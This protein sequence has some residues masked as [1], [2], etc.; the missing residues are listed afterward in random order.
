MLTNYLKIA[1]RNLVRNKVYSFI[2][3]GGLAVGMAVAMLIGLWMLDELSFNKCHDNYLK[4]GRVMTTFYNGKEPGDTGNAIAIPVADEL[5]TKYPN[6]F[7]KVALSSWN[8]GHIVAVGDKKL[9][10]EGMWVESVFPEMLSLKMVKGNQKGL[11]DPSAILLTESLAKAI[12]G[13]KDPLNKIVKLDNSMDFKVAGVYQDLPRNAEFYATKFFIPW[14]KY[15]STQPW[16]K[17]AQTQWDNHSFQ[18]FV[19]MNENADFDKST[20]KIKDVTMQHLKESVSGKESI[21]LHPMCDWHLY[22]DFKGGKSVGGR[23]QFV[24]L[25]GIIG[26]FVL[27]LACINFMNLSTARSEKRAKE[28]GVRKAIGSAKKQLIGQFLSESLLVVSVSFLVAI[29]LVEL[30]LSWFNQL[31]DKTL[32]IQWT[33][34]LFWIIGLGFTLFTGLIS[35]SYPAFYLSSFEPVKVLKGT[36]RVGRF[37]SIP[38]KVL[39]VMQFTVSIT[40]IIGTI[41]VFKQI[42]YAQNR[43][44]GYNREGLI[45]I[46]MNTPEIRNK[47]QALRDDLLKTGVVENMAQSSSPITNVWANQIGFDWKGKDPNSIPAFGTIGVTHDFGKTVN[48]QIKQ[49]RDFSRNFSTDTS[50]FILNEAAAK[51]IGFRNPVGETIKFNGSKMQVLGVIKDLVMESPFEPIKPTVFF[52]SYDWADIISVR[53]KPETPVKDALSKVETVFK[54]HDPGSPFNY[55]FVDEEYAQKFS[56]ESRIG[57]LASIFAGLAILISCLGLFGLASFMA[58]QRTKEIGFRKVLGASVRNLWQLLSKDFVVLVIISFVI[59]IPIAYY[60]LH[61]WLQNYTYRTEITWWVFALAG[62]GALVITLLTVSYQAI[63]AAV[64]NPV[65]SLRTE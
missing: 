41:I 62:S 18:L 38:R 8:F 51:V 60:Y 47:Y 36:F 1:F 34:P 28:V 5:R 21:S 32:A 56:S 55:K 52:L 2:N 37:A 29:L 65:K 22:S 25:F 45:S 20:A 12:F 11:Q 24:W 9:S 10:Q 16:L 30:S 44:I 59:S 61:N 48:W 50:G 19:E 64:A 57:T 40:L 6:D 7:K 63:K 17:D 31:A 13:D 23:I 15:V 58:E 54:K 42:K 3:I 26:M 43:P 27:L 4:L 46:P 14:Q 39:V 33:N 35:G 53:L 49:G